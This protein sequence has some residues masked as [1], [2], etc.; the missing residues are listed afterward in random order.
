MATQHRS[1]RLLP[2]IWLGLCLVLL[3]FPLAVMAFFS[4]NDSK[5]GLV[6]RGFSL[7]HYD[8]AWHN[9]SLLAAFGNSLLL[10]VVSACL[11]TLLGLGAA[12]ALERLRLSFKNAHVSLVLLPLVIPEV[13]LGIAL[14]NFFH[15][16]GWPLDLPWPW[17]LGT[18]LVA[19]ISFCIPFCAVVL[20][21]RLRQLNQELDYAAQDL[22]ASQWRTLYDITLPQLFPA[23]VTSF[24]LG[25]TLSLDD[26]VVTFFTA[27][28]AAQLLPLQVFA[29]VRFG[30]TPE[31]N[32]VTTVLVLLTIFSILV[33]AKV[34]WRK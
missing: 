24:L 32:A 30:A 22:G 28:P 31:V 17:S 18:V 9:E 33:A 25:F 11:A 21:A 23:L 8:A 7:R 15:T 14:L 12:F 10:A 1:R 26:F 27:G 16:I 6:W 2:A 19:H 5:R 3:Y 4:F 13:C 20:R 34:Y 29:M